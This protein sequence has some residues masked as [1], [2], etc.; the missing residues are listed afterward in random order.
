M[1]IFNKFAVLASLVSASVTMAQPAS[2]SVKDGITDSAAKVSFSVESS[3]HKFDGTTDSVLVLTPVV[4]FD[5]LFV[6]DLSVGVA[7]PTFEQ[8]DLGVGGLDVFANYTI[9]DGKTLGGD[10]KFTLGGGA[11]VPVFDTAF[12]PDNVVPHFDA[13][14]SVDWGTVSA[15]EAVRFDYIYDGFCF[16]P[17]LGGAVEEAVVSSE[18]ELTWNPSDWLA[19]GG[20]LDVQYATDTESLTILAG[21]EIGWTPSKHFN[22]E[23]GIGLPVHQDIDPVFDETDWVAY[24][25]FTVSF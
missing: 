7:M 17:T 22:L 6:D 20:N 4:S 1:S 25:G 23:F 19:I 10:A 16:N 5:G 2:S 14:F 24:G 18:T 3:Y 8:G 21:P 12:D 9:W 15:S 13:A 11:L